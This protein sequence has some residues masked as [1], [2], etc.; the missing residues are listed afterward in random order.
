MREEDEMKEKKR[1]R[2]ERLMAVAE[3][4]TDGNVLEKPSAKRIEK[5][6]II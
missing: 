3:E 5:K 1:L 4:H 6:Y 2:Q